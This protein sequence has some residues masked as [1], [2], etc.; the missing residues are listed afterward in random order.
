MARLSEGGLRRTV[1]VT[2]TAYA[3]GYYQMLYRGLR[4]WLAED[5]PFK[6]P[7]YSNREVP[8]D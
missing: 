2:P 6:A 1:G 8:D 4:H 7:Y 5:F 3:R